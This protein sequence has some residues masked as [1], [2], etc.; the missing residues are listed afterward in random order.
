MVSQYMLLKEHPF[1]LHRN[2]LSPS[3]SLLMN[4][5]SYALNMHHFEQTFVSGTPLSL[6]SIEKF[7]KPPFQKTVSIY[8]ECVD[9]FCLTS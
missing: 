8:P 1:V 6:H 2:I 4:N 5:P 9:I 3:I 7:V